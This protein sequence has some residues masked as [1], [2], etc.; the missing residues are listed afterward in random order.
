M[1]HHAAN[2]AVA[3]QEI[4]SAPDDEHRQILAAAEPDQLGK[5]PL[6][7]RLDP[8]LSRSADPQSGVFGKRLVQSNV[9]VRADD[10]F[11]F[12]SDDQICRQDR[13]LLVDVAGAETQNKV[14]ALEQVADVAMNP[15]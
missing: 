10:L 12:L 8:K 9:A 11:D 2:A 1:N 7:A 3:D 14:T 13:E 4:G 15:S 5:C 6:G